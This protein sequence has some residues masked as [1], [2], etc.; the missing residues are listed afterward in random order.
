MRRIAKEHVMF[1]VVGFAVGLSLGLAVGYRVFMRYTPESGGQQIERFFYVL[2]GDTNQLIVPASYAVDGDWSTKLEWN[3][4]QLG[5]FSISI[6]EN[7]TIA[8]SATELQWELKAYHTYGG[9][10]QAPLTVS[11]WNGSLW[12]QLYSLRDTEHGDEVFIETLN[13]PSDATQ[14]NEISIRTVIEYSSHTVGGILPN[15]PQRS[16]DYAEYFE[17]KLTLTNT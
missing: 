10:I 4:A 15:P 14:D 12:K 6:T 13:V 17:G 2:D 8:N 1:L 7:F 5:D 3:T 16:F 9:L 11:Y